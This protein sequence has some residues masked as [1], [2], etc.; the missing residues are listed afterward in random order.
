MAVAGRCKGEGWVRAVGR[1]LVLED[2][3]EAGAAPVLCRPMTT[4]IPFCIASL[5]MRANAGT[6]LACGAEGEGR[7]EKMRRWRRRAVSVASAAACTRTMS[8]CFQK[9]WLADQK[10]PC[11]FLRRGWHCT[12]FLHNTGAGGG[13][14][15]QKETGSP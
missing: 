15:Q 8:S 13:G 5:A 3:R 9:R 14:G 12:I 4:A 6:L 2:G 10:T 11:S 7:I 1:A